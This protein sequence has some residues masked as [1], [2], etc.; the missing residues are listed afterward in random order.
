MA[1]RMESGKSRLVKGS[2]LYLWEEVK[3]LNR[4]KIKA[5]MRILSGY[6]RMKLDQKKLIDY[7]KNPEAN[8]R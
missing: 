7:R 6:I 4:A 8:D 5:L 1:N 3:T 2:L